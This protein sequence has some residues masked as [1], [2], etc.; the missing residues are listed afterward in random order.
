LT[1]YKFEVRLCTWCR[2]ERP[3]L[4]MGDDRRCVVCGQV[5]PA[6]DLPPVIDSTPIESSRLSSPGCKSW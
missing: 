6:R 2:K 1:L 5:K 3:Y 4:I